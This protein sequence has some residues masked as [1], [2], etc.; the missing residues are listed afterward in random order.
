MDA[1][2]LCLLA[3]HATRIM[4]HLC[5]TR[6]HTDHWLRLQPNYFSSPTIDL[7]MLRMQAFCQSTQRPTF[8][9]IRRCSPFHPGSCRNLLALIIR[10]KT[11]LVMISR[12]N[13]LLQ[14]KFWLQLLQHPSIRCQPIRSR[15]HQFPDHLPQST[16][17]VFPNYPDLAFFSTYAVGSRHPLVLQFKN[18][19]VM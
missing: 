1:L 10:R 13:I 2:F 15:L 17:S 7:A 12:N 9:Y 6:P 3:R 11:C 19:R 4:G 14:E 8:L 16:Q 18:Y 5:T